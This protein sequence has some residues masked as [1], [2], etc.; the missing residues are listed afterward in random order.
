MRIQDALLASAGSAWDDW[1]QLD[2]EW[3]KSQE[4]RAFHDQF[5]IILEA[6][7]EDKPLIVIKDPRICRI[8]P[9]FLSVLEKL[10][11]QPVALFILRNPLEIAYS[12]R[13]RNGFTISKSIAVWLRHVLEAERESR[14]LPRHFIFYEELL[15]D[16][17]S[18]MNIA[19]NAINI[20]W[21]ADPEISD[22]TIDNFLTSDLRH[23]KSELKNFEKHPEVL[24]LAV[25]TYRFLGRLARGEE[26]ENLFKQLDDLHAKYNQA[27]DFFQ[28]TLGAEESATQ[29]LHMR[30]YYN[31]RKRVEELE[32]SLVQQIELNRK[33]VTDLTELNEANVRH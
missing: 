30:T 19:A 12:L 4:A 9:F 31:L 20:S 22:K 33:M 11:I 14:R 2:A 18:E 7:Y 26:P 17:R 29:Q 21:P 15:K 25:E 13:R 27:C 8:M 3:Y 5:R 10:N 6:E 16:W 32:N 1:R 24:W 28:I 23:E